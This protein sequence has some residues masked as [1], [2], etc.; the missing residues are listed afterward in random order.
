MS[1]SVYLVAAYAI[2]GALTFVLVFSM[3]A[4][5]R[6]LQQE[7]ADLASRLGEAGGAE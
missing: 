3:W 2:F 1:I 6:Q 5:Q 4:R 7:I